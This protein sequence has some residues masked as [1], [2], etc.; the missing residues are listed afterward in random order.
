LRIMIENRR[1]LMEALNYIGSKIDKPVNAYLIGGAA[2]MWHSL[3]DATK[4][5]DI[6]TSYEGADDIVSALRLHGKVEFKE[7]VAG[8][9]FLRVML[10][11][12]D[13]V[14]Q[15]FIQSIYSTE[16]YQRI[17]AAECEVLR[18]GKLSYKIPDIKMLITLKD[19][20]MHALYNEY[21]NL[22][23]RCSLQQN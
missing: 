15:I 11:R 21:Q 10:P 22:K 14:L 8:V 23:E 5:V 2:M 18:C 1:Q 19:I 3:K 6:I 4:D 12:R 16:D 17:E 9:T 20:Q 7:G 13:L